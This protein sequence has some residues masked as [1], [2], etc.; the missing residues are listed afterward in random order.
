MKRITIGGLLLA[1]AA[2]GAPPA[3]GQDL[4]FPSE[5]SFKVRKGQLLTGR[6]QLAF[7][8]DLNAPTDVDGYQ[9]TL[10]EFE[11]LGYSSNQK[12]VSTVMVDDLSLYGHVVWDGDKVLR[13]LF[14]VRNCRSALGGETS[15]FRYKEG[16]DGNELQTEIFTPY[17]ALDLVSSILVAARATEEKGFKGRD[18]NFMFNSTTRQVSLV[19][20]DS[21]E[22]DTPLG[23]MKTR[24]LALVHKDSGVELYRFYVGRDRQ[25]AFPVRMVYEDQRE[26]TIEFLVDKVRWGA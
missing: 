23:R 3:V 17:P 8:V 6:F 22:I 12:L 11:S 10:S 26:G 4:P 5:L 7:G 2:A 9:L 19:A 25:G 18:Y 21:E 13:Q 1:L 14:L 15:C 24:V 20:R 16:T